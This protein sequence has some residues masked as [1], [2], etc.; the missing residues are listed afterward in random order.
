MSDASHK[1]A[2]EVAQSMRKKVAE[3]AKTVLHNS[4]RCGST[5]TEKGFNSCLDQYFKTE[6]ATETY[7]FTDQE[8]T[9]IQNEVSNFSSISLVPVYRTSLRSSKREVDGKMPVAVTDAWLSDSQRKLRDIEGPLLTQAKQAM[10]DSVRTGKTPSRS[11]YLSYLQVEAEQLIAE[12][13]DALDD[14]AKIYLRNYSVAY[15]KNACGTIYDASLAATPRDVT[16]NFP[17]TP[18]K[19][20]SN[21]SSSQKN[22][23]STSSVSKYSFTNQSFSGSDM[24]CSIDITL[25]N[26][27]KIVKVI[28]SLQ[29]LTYSIHNDRR[30]VRSIGN[31]NAKD[32]VFGQRTI[33]GTLIFAVFNKHWAHEI[34]DEYKAAGANVHFLMDELPP[35]QITISAANEYGY[36]ARLA[37]YGVRIVNE[38]QVMAVNDVYTE[39]SYQFVATDLDYLSD[40]TGYSKKRGVNTQQ[41]PSMSSNPAIPTTPSLPVVKD[42]EQEEE[43]PE[44]QPA[45]PTQDP[46]PPTPEPTA[47]ANPYG[48]NDLRQALT[49]IETQRT[50]AM[51]EI[52]ANA[53]AGKYK[54]ESEERRVRVAT[55]ALFDSKAA[56][57]KEYF[58][59]HG[60]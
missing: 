53:A 36:S 4:E 51:E 38:G 54:T 2:L 14:Q 27:T 52:R 60:G 13:G 17:W 39:N 31:M 5:P 29:T 42:P 59:T 28:G 22:I 41:L 44:P 58:D 47:P 46:A 40:T 10:S 33:A 15:V 26:G 48:T 20:E 6:F 1:K 50:S 49:N 37:L 23:I 7:P 55:N 43:E 19:E 16:N 11:Q 18:N 25:P 45:E 35:F 21:G 24:A 56:A 3:Y 32:Y 57:A 9:L 34:M 8:K 30:P 12:Q